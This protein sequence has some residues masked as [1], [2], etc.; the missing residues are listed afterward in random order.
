MS[1]EYDTPVTTLVCDTE[2][3]LLLLG[4]PTGDSLGLTKAF[5]E[6]DGRSSK[7]NRYPISSR[8]SGSFVHR[9]GGNV[10]KGWEV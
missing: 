1:W 8:T 10:G 9:E 4:V 3:Y 5:Y 2:R 7:S 6:V